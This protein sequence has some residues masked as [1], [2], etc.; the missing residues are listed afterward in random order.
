MRRKK[1]NNPPSA[2]L[3][4]TELTALNT[5]LQAKPLSTNSITTTMDPISWGIDTRVLYIVL[6]DKIT[7]TGGTLP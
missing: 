2:A 5:L 6:L 3:Q 7:H 4:P 1:K